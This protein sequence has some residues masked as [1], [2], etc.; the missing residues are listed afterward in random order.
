MHIFFDVDGV[1]IDGF[2]TKVERRNRW[3]RTLK[4]DTGIDPEIFQEIFSSWFLEVLQ[5][6]LGFEEELDRWLQNHKYNIIAKDIIDYWHKK[7]SNINTDLYSMVKILSSKSETNLYVATNQT[8]ERA[9][10]LWNEL[11]FKN[12]FQDIYYSAR[13]KCLKS[14]PDYFKKIE[15]ELGLKPHHQE[16]LYFDDDPVNIDVAKK[17]GWEAVLF[18]TV[19]DVKSHPYITRILN[20]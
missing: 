4:E 15:E 9:S 6:R 13:L 7:D 8:H 3:D 17:R 5:G 2:H 19:D 20:Q 10:Y 14:N 18:D 11:G 1:L 16:V 12:H